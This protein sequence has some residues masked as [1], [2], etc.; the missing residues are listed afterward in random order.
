LRKFLLKL[1]LIFAL[2][3]PESIGLTAAALDCEVGQARQIKQASGQGTPKKAA[4]SAAAPARA[5]E[6]ESVGSQWFRL[7]DNTASCIDYKEV[8]R[9]FQGAESAYMLFYIRRDQF[10]D[11]SIP[12]LSKVREMSCL[13][14]RGCADGLWPT[15]ELQAM[16]DKENKQL[17]EA[18]EVR[19]VAVHPWCYLTHQTAL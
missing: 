15:Q 16:V 17:I 4:S 11:V 9:T 10:E 8:E 13:R 18:R 3:L 6:E 7:D 5:V 2:P 19:M 14:A 12:R 1:P